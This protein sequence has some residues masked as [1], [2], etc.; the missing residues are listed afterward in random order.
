MVACG[1]MVVAN[2]TGTRIGTTGSGTLP[3]PVRRDQPCRGGS[4]ARTT[5]VSAVLTVR[6]WRHLAPGWPSRAGQNPAGAVRPR[7]LR[8]VLANLPRTDRA[9]SLVRGRRTPTRI[10]GASHGDPRSP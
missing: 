8:V 3:S 1:P 9:R 6:G 2:V 4:C 7:R 10:A 5:V